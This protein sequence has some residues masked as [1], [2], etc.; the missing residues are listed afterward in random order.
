MPTYSH[1]RLETYGNCPRLYKLQYIDKV[2]V[3][4]VE[5]VE[6][7]LG[8]R[9]H[10][11]LEKLYKDVRMMCLPTCEEV[12]AHYDKIWDENW[13]EGVNI[14]KTTTRT[15][16]ASAWPI[17]TRGTSPSTRPGPSR[18]SSWSPFRWTKRSST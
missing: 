8:G 11:A 12:L 15:S 1:S 17:T 6:A 4:E 7:F 14:V 18:S 16:G 5:S 13:H 3:G 2:E 9:V 10:E